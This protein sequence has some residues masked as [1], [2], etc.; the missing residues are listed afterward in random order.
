MQSWSRPFT[1]TSRQ[2]YI[3]FSNFERLTESFICLDGVQLLLWLV[4]G[5]NSERNIY[6]YIYIYI[7]I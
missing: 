5:E 2:D 7:Y 1:V 6:I 3:G 4:T